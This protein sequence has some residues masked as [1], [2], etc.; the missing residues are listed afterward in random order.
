MAPKSA[1]MVALRGGAYC[2]LGELDKAGRDIDLALRLDPKSADAFQRRGILHWVQGKLDEATQ[3]LRKA[4]KLCPDN[5][6]YLSALAGLLATC[7]DPEHRD[8]AEAVRHARRACELSGWKDGHCLEMLAAACAEAGDFE[9]AIKWQKKAIED[10]YYARIEGK[11]AGARLRLYEQHKPY[12]WTPS[13]QWR[14]FG[15]T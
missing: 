12:R 11:N 9:E 8:G 5:P 13:F 10:P 7:L 4:V 6:T 1:D 15:L 14:F 3:D 2:Y